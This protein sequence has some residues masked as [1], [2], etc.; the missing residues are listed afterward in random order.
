M[1]YIKPYSIIVALASFAFDADAFSPAM[2]SR[3]HSIIAPFFVRSNHAMD[4]NIRSSYVSALQASNVGYDDLQP[5]DIVA[6]STGSL[7]VEALVALLS[8]DEYSHAAVVSDIAPKVFEQVGSI[9][10]R[11][12]DFTQDESRLG[13]LTTV[14]RFEGIDVDA[15]LSVAQADVDNKIHYSWDNL[16]YLAALLFLKDPSIVLTAPD[17]VTKALKLY[18]TALLQSPRPTSESTFC[19][20]FVFKCFYEADI[21]LKIEN[22]SIIRATSRSSI[23]N[24]VMDECNSIPD[25]EFE[26]VFKPMDRSDRIQTVSD[27]DAETAL[28][29]AA[30]DILKILK[31]ENKMKAASAVD[32]DGGIDVE[33]IDSEFIQTVI[34]FVL[35]VEGVNL[36]DSL[37]Y[38]EKVKTALSNIDKKTLVTPGELTRIANENAVKLGSFV[39]PK[40]E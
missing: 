14:T 5:G 8:G 24:L 11:K 36:D 34:D 26:V 32:A 18:F 28:N 17:T 37:S 25:E 12:Y 23:L 1:L 33:L 7:P 9:P 3:D 29:E 16:G 38:K 19:S 31:G 40:K 20:E 27:V 15:V 4:S 35:A 22:P 6:W 21:E 13:R 10:V 30:G 39:L 2:R